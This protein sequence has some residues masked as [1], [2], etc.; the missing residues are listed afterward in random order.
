MKITHLNDTTA[1][2]F[3]TLIAL[4]TILLVS[5]ICPAVTSKT[6]THSTASAFLKGETENT[7][8]G[9]RGTISLAAQASEI[10]LGGLLKDAWIVNAIV[11]DADGN[12]YIAT[13]PNG[14]I[15][16][17]TADGK[18]EKIYPVDTNT[19]A[20]KDIKEDS[21]T[22]PDTDPNKADIEP[23]L[24]LHVF[25]IAIDDKGRLLAGISGEKCELIRF[26]GDKIET[27]FTSEDVNYILEITLDKTGNIFLGTGPNG[28]IYRLSSDGKH[29]TLVYDS[30]D[31]N[32]L[33]LAIDTNNFIYAGSDKR[34]LVYKIHPFD[35]SAVVLYDSPQDEITDL[36]IDDEGNVLATATSATSVGSQARSIGIS[37][38]D[39]L[40]RPDTDEGTDSGA[41]TD[42]DSNSQ[43]SNIEEL[44]IANTE[45]SD[46]KSTPEMPQQTE[47]GAM[48][49][50]ASH[51]YKIDTRG[52]VTN[53]FNDNA[54]FFNMLLEDNKIVLGTGNKA[55]LFIINT[56]TEQKTIAYEDETASQ[57]TALAADGGRIL[58][59]TSNPAKLVSLSDDYQAEGTYISKPVDAGQPAR[60]GKLQIDA[61][62]PKGCKILL[63]ARS[64]NVEEPNDPTFS[65]WTEDTE[66]TDATQ[67]D[68]PIGRYCQYRLTFKTED[69]KETPVL[70]RVAVP[71]VVDNIA[72]RVTMVKVSRSKDL[73]KAATKQITF[74][75]IDTNSDK[76]VYLIEFRK[77]GRTGWIE[78]KDKLTSPKFE[79]NTKTVEDGRYEVRVTADD[80]RSNTTTTALTGTRVSDIIV[81]DNTAPVVESETI[82]TKG[83]TATLKLSLKDALSVIGNLSYTVNSNEDW[84]STLP[85]DL[86]YDTT[87]E[88]FTIVIEDL[89][90]GENVIAVKFTDEAKNIKYKSYEAIVK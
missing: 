32:I 45:K 58:I 79:W 57:I 9:S 21:F 2:K 65:D 47:R 62:L 34:G 28:Q 11:K 72:P 70:S 89:E 5:A 25:A 18:A 40:G 66:I 6:T 48:P 87:Q 16:K 75:A 86:I 3:T 59:G 78:L 63:A 51:I 27:I 26:S 46:S 20:D 30:Q 80:I 43:E 23:F 15:I 7:I 84:M 69:T 76:L 29:S 14:D 24:N 41:G 36:I 64:G 38:G 13:S 53:V 73:K 50:S 33:S 74:V 90:A 56:K 52:F 71:H 31:D 60:W 19:D 77:T 4:S 12:I 39:K 49:K 44:N 54:V 22:K 88:D 82:T 68:C 17:Y 37:A 61:E 10:D 8:I 85:N 55:E 42:S 83:A 35:E 81:V 1:S 67:L